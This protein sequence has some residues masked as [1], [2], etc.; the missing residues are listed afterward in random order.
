MDEDE[1]DGVE[2]HTARNIWA[3][4]IALVL[5]PAL[6]AW[7]VRLSALGLQCAPDPIRAAA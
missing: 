3:I 2:R 6:M 4:C 1:S 7:I 5:G